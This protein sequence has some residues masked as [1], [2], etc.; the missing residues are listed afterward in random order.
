MRTIAEFEIAGLPKMT[1]A[2]GRAHWT[3]KH[4]EAKKWKRLV[5]IECA[6]LGISNLGLGAASLTL[7]RHSIKEPDMDGLVSGFKHVVDGLVAAQVIV[8][9]RPSVIG[10]SR[11]RWQTAPPS[12]GKV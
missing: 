3:V 10:Q 9:D 6:R 12:Q 5:A 1:N 11:Y 4:R 8:D 2:I 7:T